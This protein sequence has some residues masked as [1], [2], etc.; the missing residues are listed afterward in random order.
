MN[1]LSERLKSLGVIIN[2]KESDPNTTDRFEKPLTWEIETTK[3][4]K[5]LKTIDRFPRGMPFGVSRIDFPKHF[6]RILKFFSIN[7]SNQSGQESFFFLDT[8]TTGLPGGTGSYP[9]LV[10]LG[11]FEQDH[12]L[13]VQYFL[14]NP[15]EEKA[16]LSAISEL[17]HPNDTIITFNGKS[18]DVPLLR[19]RYSL[20]RLSDPF[21]EIN[22]IDL[23]PLTRRLWRNRIQSCSLAN[24]ELKIINII[25]EKNDVPGWRIPQLYFEYLHSGDTH[26]ITGIM[27]HNA[28]DIISLVVLLN[29]IS[30]ILTN[31]DD[32][33]HNV[34]GVDLLSLG[35]IFYKFGEVE[36][37]IKQFERYLNTAVLMDNGAILES[38]TDILNRLAALNNKLGNFLQA[39][40]YWERASELGSLEACIELA[41]IAEH[42]LKDYA[43]AISWAQKALTLLNNYQFKQNEHISKSKLIH[44]ICRLNKKIGIGPFNKD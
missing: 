40:S 8:E 11:I 30:N 32:G 27:Y 3:F 34:N 17:F 36:N 10:G 35:G 21:T 6:Y 4:G 13:L 9:F 19:N 29:H 1:N 15:A 37:A 25:R 41:K 22:H 42:R 16:L 26:D 2:T 24:I 7:L 14:E 12:F 28:K 5:V 18:F 44:R 39:S 38:Q 23:L 43:M 20:H 31:A 33:S